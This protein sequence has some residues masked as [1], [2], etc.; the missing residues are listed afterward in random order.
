MRR[1]SSAWSTSP[2][3]TA[4]PRKKS[5]SGFDGRR[6]DRTRPTATATRRNDWIASRLIY[7]ELHADLENSEP[8]VARLVVTANIPLIESLPKKGQTA[9]EKIMVRR[10]IV[11]G[12]EKSKSKIVKREAENIKRIIAVEISLHWTT[13]WK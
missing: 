2:L 3:T 6:H 1:Q 9:L 5:S 11:E 7:P 4:S 12:E 10:G 13:W 8:D